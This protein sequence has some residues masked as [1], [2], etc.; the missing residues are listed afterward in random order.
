VGS[1]I[2]GKCTVTKASFGLEFLLGVLMCGLVGDE[3]G[4]IALR[5]VRRRC[6]K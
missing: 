3:N 4:E 5:M 1:A 2:S 6:I